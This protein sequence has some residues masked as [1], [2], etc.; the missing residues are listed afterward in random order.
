M[1][2]TAK[3]FIAESYMYYFITLTSIKSY[4]DGTTFHKKFTLVYRCFD[5]FVLIIVR[6]NV[7]IYFCAHLYE[8]SC[9]MCAQ[10]ASKN[11]CTAVE[12]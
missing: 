1:I 4:Y 12:I 7:Y 6:K 11:L 8:R 2:K 9:F 3:P 10:R 5:M